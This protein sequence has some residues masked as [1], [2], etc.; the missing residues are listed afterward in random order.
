MWG[1]LLTCV[2]NSMN[3]KMGILQILGLDTVVTCHKFGIK[4]VQENKRNKLTLLFFALQ[5]LLEYCH[6]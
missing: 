2:T 6:M 4:C 3:G 5:F 1:C